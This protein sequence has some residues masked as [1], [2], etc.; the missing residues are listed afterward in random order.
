M[1]KELQDK[2]YSKYP[3]IFVQKDW[4]IQESCM[5]W[6]ID[7]PDSWY[8][9]IDCLCFRIQII[10]DKGRKEY[11]RFPFG[12]FFYKLFKNARFYGILFTKKVAQVEFTQVK[13]KFGSLRVYYSGGDNYID[14]LIYFAEDLTTEVCAVCG[15]NQNVESTNGWITFLCKNC[16]EENKDE[17]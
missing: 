1:R 16:F 17:S 4:S 8:S 2:L 10:C 5:P 13:E 11:I 7:T 12:G 15:S 6:G 3:K 9:I 14:D